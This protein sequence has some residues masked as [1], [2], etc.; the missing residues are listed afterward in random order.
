[1]EVPYVELLFAPIYIFVLCYALVS[2][3]RMLIIP[4]WCSIALVLAFLPFAAINLSLADFVFHVAASLLVLGLGFIFYVFA[5]FGGGDA[6]LLSA[7][8]LWV[9]ISKAANFALLMALIGLLM[10]IGLLTLRRVLKFYPEQ[11]SGS[12]LL[13]RPIAWVKEGAFPYGIAISGAGLA[14]VPEVFR[15]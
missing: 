10:A 9:G 2:D 7:V 13:R 11:F 12:F 4:N 1:M 5:W 6:K 15:F 8:I 14:Y 3:F